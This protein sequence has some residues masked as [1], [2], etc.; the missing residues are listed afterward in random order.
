MVVIGVGAIFLMN[1][2][3][4]RREKELAR[5]G[6]GEEIERIVEKLQ[7]EAVEKTEEENFAEGTDGKETD[8]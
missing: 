6:G 4:K 5:Q 3:V 1:R 7:G 8:K 2:F